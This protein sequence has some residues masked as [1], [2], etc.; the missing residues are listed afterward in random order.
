MVGPWRRT[1]LKACQKNTPVG[2]QIR[3]I[4]LGWL[5]SMRGEERDHFVERC[6]EI[7][8]VKSSGARYSPCSTQDREAGIKMQ[9]RAEPIKFAQRD[10]P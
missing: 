1:S 4:S 3:R 6:G 2:F 9:T 8:D 5:P 10:E 7:V